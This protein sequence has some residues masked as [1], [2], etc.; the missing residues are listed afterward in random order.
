LIA[1]KFDLN[2]I[3]IS[4]PKLFDC[5]FDLNQIKNILANF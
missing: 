5:K 4:E 1:I 3:K 2:Q